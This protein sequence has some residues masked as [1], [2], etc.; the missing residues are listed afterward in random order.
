MMVRS[1]TSSKNCCSE[2]GSRVALELATLRLQNML[3]ISIKNWNELAPN[4][5]A[6]DAGVLTQL[7][8]CMYMTTRRIK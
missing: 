5:D 1:S 6:L 2:G 3:G 4:E 8:A 7:G